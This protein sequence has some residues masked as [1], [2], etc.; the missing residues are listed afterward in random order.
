M[1]NGGSESMGNKLIVGVLIAVFT[2][3]VGYLVSYADQH[4]KDQIAFVS[5]QI[6]KLYGPL[7]AL[8]QANDMAWVHFQQN[9]WKERQSYFQIDTPL[10]AVEVDL[11]RL[12]MRNVFQ[13]M[14]VRMEEAIVNNA[15][16]L[17]GEQMP[18]MF[19]QFISH[20]EAYK[21]VIAS[22]KEG[23]VKADGM[24][25]SANVPP[26]AFPS[27]PA[28][29]KCI[30]AQYRNLKKL[31]QQLQQQL[32]GRLEPLRQELPSDCIVHPIVSSTR[33]QNTGRP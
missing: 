10:Q 7:F 21:S 33:S 24:S 32:I 14:N 25:A 20:T 9:Y 3:T 23:P 29:S 12:W 28:F 13:P 17:V 11:W 30:T 16:L 27:Q 18:S 26:V 6:E 5:A 2:A 19:L 31:Q 8:V 15:Q 1:S 22:W 4:R